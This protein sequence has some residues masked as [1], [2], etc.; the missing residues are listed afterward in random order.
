MNDDHRRVG[1]D[2][3]TT[4]SVSAQHQQQAGTRLTPFTIDNIL[5]K[6]RD[7]APA[8]QPLVVTNRPSGGL[9]ENNEPTSDQSRYVETAGVI[10]TTSKHTDPPADTY[11]SS[12]ENTTSLNLDELQT[13]L[14]SKLQHHQHHHQTPLPLP[15]APPPPPPPPPPHRHHHHYHP[16]H[17]SHLSQQQTGALPASFYSHQFHRHLNILPSSIDGMCYYMCILNVSF[18]NFSLYWLILLKLQ[19]SFVFLHTMNTFKLKF[20]KKLSCRSETAQC[21]VSPNMLL[22]HSRSLKVIRND[23]RELSPSLLVGL[24]RCN[25]RTVSGGIQRFWRDLENLVTGFFTVIKNVPFNR[26]LYDFLL[27]RHCKYSSI[28][29]HLLVIW[30]W[31]IVTLKSGLEVFQ[32][33]WNWYHLKAWVRF[34]F[35]FHRNY[36][37]ILYHFRDKVKYWSKIAIFYTPFHSTPQ[38]GGPCRNAVIPFGA[39][40]LEWRGYTVVKKFED[41]SSR[42][43]RIPA[44][45]GLTDGR[46]DKHLAAV[47][48]PMHTSRG[49]THLFGWRQRR[50]YPASLSRFLPILFLTLFIRVMTS[51]S[52]Q[53]LADKCMYVCVCVYVC[54]Y[55]CTTWISWT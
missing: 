6:S 19:R 46:T 22:S 34:L 42:F 9:H 21:F 52:L 47:V 10:L 2:A 44:C 49:K 53:L 32:G 41:T 14:T 16:H 3:V 54:V 4:I 31:I 20:N 24:L 55:V 40:K 25:S 28:S 51:P 15:P 29:Y 43:D 13:F 35:G 8:A 26:P 27:V 36:G 30:R 1:D 7:L 33:L 39:E 17:S 38:L 5:G 12:G 11:S 45:D 50:T 18:V 37:S 48:R 23:T